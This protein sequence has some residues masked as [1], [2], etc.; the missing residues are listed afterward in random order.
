MSVAM[1]A[2]IQYITDVDGERTDVILS[3]E[4]YEKLLE[5]VH[6]M[7]VVGDRLDEEPISLNELKERLT[8]SLC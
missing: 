2:A 5:D 1:T 3:L 7:A 4:Q 6:D 8:L